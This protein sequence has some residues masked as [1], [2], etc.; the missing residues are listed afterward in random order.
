MAE[1]P[2][3]FLTIPE[4]AA[5]LQVPEETVQGWIK[6]RAL[7]IVGAPDGVPVVRAHDPL[8]LVEPL[9]EAEVADV[10]MARDRLRPPL[11]ALAAKLAA[12]DP[13]RLRRESA[14]PLSVHNGDGCA[15]SRPARCEVGA[16]LAYWTKDKRSR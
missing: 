5:I 3:S 13:M 8:E 9:V 7:P 2:R 4:A 11:E 14:R 1:L 15:G 12:P 10:T 6:L 16:Q